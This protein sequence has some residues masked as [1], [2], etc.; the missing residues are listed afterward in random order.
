MLKN[1]PLILLTLLIP[2]L[3][4]F[5][6]TE[7]TEPTTPVSNQANNTLDAH[8]K[9]RSHFFVQAE[10]LFWKPAI[11]QLNYVIEQKNPD[12]PSSKYDGSIKSA[13]FEW[14]F[15]YRLSTGYTLPHDRW[16]ISAM[17]TSISNNGSKKERAAHNL[18]LLQTEGYQNTITNNIADVKG[19]WSIDLKQI[20]LALGKE[21]HP[22]PWIKI[23]P[24]GGLR[25]AWIDQDSD[26]DFFL[27]TNNEIARELADWDFW[28]LG[29]VAGASVD[30]ILAKNW[31]L[32]SF[33]DYSILWGFYA[34]DQHQT[35][36]ASAHY[37]FQK[38][39]RC[40]RGVYDLGLGIKWNYLFSNN[41]W[42]LSFKASYEYHLYPEQNQ[43]LYNTNFVSASQTSSGAFLN[44]G[45]DLIYQGIAL[46]G[47]FDF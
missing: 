6:P 7:Q 37:R 27:N 8:P 46:S 30:W 16:D 15:G 39:M 1:T 21:F 43:F 9:S 22:S 42:K 13:T 12:H 24:M 17:W 44:N 26:V 19:R 10:A 40:A 23:R 45:G 36:L 31:S 5:R 14:N 3:S 18:R 28:G 34:V 29:F 35:R 2:L 11:D 38:S 33:A 4:S 41:R 32:F 25:S 20:E 47:Q